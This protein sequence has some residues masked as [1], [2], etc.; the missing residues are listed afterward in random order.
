[1]EGLDYRLVIIGSVTG[2]QRLIDGN[3]LDGDI[4]FVDYAFQTSGFL[5][6]A[7]ASLAFNRRRTDVTGGALTTPV[8]DA[9]NMHFSIGADKNF[10]NGWSVSADYRYVDRQETISPAVSNDFRVRV[11]KSLGSFKVWLTGS[12]R[13]TD[14]EFSTED[15]D[16][17]QY[18]LGISGRV[19]SRTRLNYSVDYLEDLGGSLLRN[20]WQHRFS[21]DWRYRDVLLNVQ[22]ATFDESLGD[23][24]ND[25]THVTAKVT[26]F[27]R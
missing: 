26:R 23:D 22:A 12:Y 10:G 4:V 27:F 8:N 18:R 25:S 16:Q 24:T 14:Q 1:V 21:L 11:S 15:T 3:I 20:H 13:N 17:V 7:R 19:F 2:I 9:D 5:Q 6:Y